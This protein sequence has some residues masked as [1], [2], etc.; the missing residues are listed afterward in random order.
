[1]RSFNKIAIIGVGLIGGSIGLAAQ[2]RGIARH[3]VGVFRR[4]STMARALRMKAVTSVSMDI[5][6]GVKDAD[7]VIIATPVSLIPVMAKR[8]APFMKKGAILTDAGSVKGFVVKEIS[9]AIPKGVRFVGSHPM[10]GS[11]KTSVRFARADLFQGAF[12]ILTMAQRTDKAA[13]AVIR[14]FW[15]S[16]GSKVVVATPEEH[17]RI[18]ALVSHLPHVIAQE[19]CILQDKKSLPYAAGGFKD[20]TRI[21]SS[22]P[23]MWMDIFMANRLE[24]TRAIDRFIEELE[25]FKTDL[26]SGRT[27]KILA[28]SRMAKAIRD[29]I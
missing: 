12:T 6:E 15:A 20:T 24:V 10:A 27:K 13:L 26:K 19:L 8:C 18:V 29:R 2:K 14:R 9:K 25:T 7:I 22:D 1:M 4:T 5:A 16:L 3:V 11:E 17:D 23:D 21:A 28:R